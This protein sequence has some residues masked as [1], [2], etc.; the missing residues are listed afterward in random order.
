[1][2]VPL[3][4]Q[5]ING[6]PAPLTRV[7]VISGTVAQARFR[8]TP[9]LAPRADQPFDLA[10]VY[11][12]ASGFEEGETDPYFLLRRVF[13]E[14]ATVVAARIEWEGIFT[15]LAND[16]EAGET[17]FRELIEP[18]G[19]EEITREWSEDGATLAMFAELLSWT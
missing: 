12:G 14:G 16:D 7:F 18:A 10:L 3:P 8:L 13:D 2:R 19:P 11:L 4:S 1:M 9:S 6:G 17:V 5:P 15:L